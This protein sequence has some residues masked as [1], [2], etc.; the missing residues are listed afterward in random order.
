MTDTKL[1]FGEMLFEWDE[2]KNQKNIEKHG[3]DFSRILK[4]FA[5]ENRIEFFDEFHSDEEDRWQVIGKID[6]ILFVVYTERGDSTRII[7]ARKAT[8]RER[9]I[10]N[11]S[12]ENH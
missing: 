12:A 10:Y 3:I 1:K 2:D 9:R 5:D 6:E 7:S 8:A 4:I 11:D